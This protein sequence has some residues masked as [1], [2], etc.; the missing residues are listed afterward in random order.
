MPHGSSKGQEQVASFQVLAGSA[1]SKEVRVLA[2]VSGKS[3]PHSPV[4]IPGRV[5]ISLVLRKRVKAAE[6]IS[7]VGWTSRHDDSWGIW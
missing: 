2:K 7:F 3:T 1:D 5:L 6:Q 4:L